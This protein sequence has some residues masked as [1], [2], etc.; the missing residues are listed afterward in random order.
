MKHFERLWHVGIRME[1]GWEKLAKLGMEDV[2]ALFG[3][4]RR[5]NDLDLLHSESLLCGG[6]NGIVEN[7]TLVHAPHVL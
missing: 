4:L 5:L 3:S 7:R 2:M 6:F 1:E